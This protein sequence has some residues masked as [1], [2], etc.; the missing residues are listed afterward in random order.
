MRGAAK[1]ATLATLVTLLGF[2]SLARVAAQSV[3]IPSTW[4]DISDRAPMF[5]DFVDAS[6]RAAAT[7]NFWVGYSFP[8]RD[9]VHVGCDERR[10]RS[11]SFALDGPRLYFGDDAGDVRSREC[12]VSFGLFLRFNDQGAEVI[13][14]RLLT[15]RRA[16]SRIDDAVVWA[17]DRDADESVAFLRGAVLEGSDVGAR[18]ITTSSDS[19][20]ARLLAAV[21]LHDSAGA[22][23]VVFASLN[24]QQSTKLRESAAFWVAQVGGDE[25]LEHLLQTARDDDASEVRKQSIFWLGQVAG[26]RATAHLAE[27]AEDDP[28][29]E[30]RA[31]AVFALSQSEDDAAVDALIRI[32]RTHDNREVVKAAL[33]WLGQSGDARVVELFEELLFGRRD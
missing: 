11:V 13:E 21:A 17:G 16:A 28:D 8:L 12:D 2:F 32:V 14:A 30:V 19:V 23:E 4:I 6:R 18:T 3:D 27:I 15:L 9:G 31:S 10:G 5:D 29:S 25:G 7:E 22:I 26:D 24:P 1:G 20:R 33:F